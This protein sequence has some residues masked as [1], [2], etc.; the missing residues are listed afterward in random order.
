MIF[1]SSLL[2]LK[3]SF[4][5]LTGTWSR[6]N[7]YRDLPIH[8]WSCVGWREG[9]QAV[10]AQVWAQALTYCVILGALPNPSGPE[11]SHLED[12]NDQSRLTGKDLR[13]PVAEAAY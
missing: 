4:I 10:G 8:L 6:T 3:I 7:S 5:L 9:L 13:I 11:V 2:I 12:G 1:C